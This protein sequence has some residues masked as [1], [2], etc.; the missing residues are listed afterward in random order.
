MSATRTMPATL[1]R[2]ELKAKIDSGDQFTLVETLPEKDFRRAHL[3]GA[4]DLP[5]RRLR[6]LAPQVLHEEAEKKG[7]VT[8]FIAPWGESISIDDEG[9]PIVLYS[10]SPT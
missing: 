4:I 7:Q 6:E 2:D 1:S 9:A 8:T 10:A 5:L 3:P